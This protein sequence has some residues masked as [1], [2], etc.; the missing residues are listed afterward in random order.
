MPAGAACGAK[1]RTAVKDRRSRPK[2]AAGCARTARFTII[3]KCNK[4]VDLAIAG[5]SGRLRAAG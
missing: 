4:I 1:R 2:G 3:T 5:S